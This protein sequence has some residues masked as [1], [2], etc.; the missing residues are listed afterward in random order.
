MLQYQITAARPQDEPY[1]YDSWLRGYKDSPRTAKWNQEDYQDFQQPVI[2]RILQDSRALVARPIDW[3][4]GIYGYLVYEQTADTFVLHWLSVK[5][6]YRKLGIATALIT[7]A[8]PA[9]HTVFSHLR[10]PYTSILQEHGFT[11]APNRSE[12]R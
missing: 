8:H 5:S 1:I 7:A 12:L 10:P 3:D 2:K 6:A 9:G 11:F 4:A